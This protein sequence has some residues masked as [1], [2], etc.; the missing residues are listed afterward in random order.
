MRLQV[1]WID[2]EWK[3]QDDFIGEAEQFN[4]DI[5][6]TESHEE[7]MSLLENKS[8]FFHAVILDA[9]VKLNEESQKT[10]LT[11]LK[12]S[13][14]RLIEINQTSYLPFFIFTGQPDYMDN[15]MFR[16]SYGDFFKKG[17]D[18]QKLYDAIFGEVGKSKE[19]QARKELPEAFFVFDQSILNS[20]SKSL[21]IEIAENIKQEDFRKQNI[22]VQRDLLE[23][24]W[25]T[26][27]ISFPCIPKSFFD[28]RFDNKPNHEWCTMF[29]ENRA[30]R[31]KD[32]EH[33]LNHNIP[34][35]ISSAMRFLKESVNQLSHLNDDEIIKLPLLTNMYLLTTILCWL[36]KFVSQ[37]YPNYI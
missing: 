15:N 35:T 30:I 4:I 11:G 23:S 6:P 8:N 17:K 31:N 27:H 22:N 32:G 37:N 34:K 5:H 20:K 9:K 33:R 36:P 1:L 7:G 14:D 29:F 26:L 18:N 28:A 21:F 10:D 25:K 12:A 16:E 19:M 24:I 3:K 13:R 2:D